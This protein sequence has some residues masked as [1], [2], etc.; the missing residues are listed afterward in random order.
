VIER[1]PQNTSSFAWSF[2]MTE[3]WFY[4]M[5]GEEFGPVPLAGLKELAE[6]GTISE[7]DEVR[8]AGSADWVVAG[9]V[10]QLGLRSNG[11][12]SVAVA[13][14]GSDAEMKTVSDADINTFSVDAGVDEWFC[15]LG[16]QELGPL[17]IDEL[18]KYAEY[19]QLTADDEV[20]L[21]RNGKWRR[22]GSIGRLVSVLP[23]KSIEKT[24]VPTPVRNQTPA[25]EQSVVSTAD[26]SAVRAKAAPTTAAAAAVPAPVAVPDARV[27]YEVAYEQAKAQIAQSMLAQAEATFKAA[28]EQAKSQVAWAL[29]ANVDRHWWG[30]ASSVEFGP[31]EFN[32]VLGLAKSGQ[33]KPTDLVRNGQFAQFGPASNVPGLFNAVAMIAKAAEALALAKSQAQAAVALAAPSAIVPDAITKPA[34]VPVAVAEPAPTARPNSDPVRSSA[35]PVR[36]TSDPMVSTVPTVSPAARREGVGSSPEIPTRGDSSR[37]NAPGDE[38]RPSSPVPS[39]ENR[40]AGYSSGMGGGYSS[41]MSTMSSYGSQQRPA[42]YPTKP[43]A[44]A[45]R[46]SESTFFSGMKESLK[47]PKAIGSMAVIAFVLLIVGW[48]YLPKSRGAD[49]KRYQAL[50]GLLDE[51]RTARTNPTLMTALMPKAKALGKEIT[52]AV[53]SQASSADRPKQMLLWISRD[54]VPRLLEGGMNPMTAEKAEA[55]YAMRLKEAAYELGLEK[56]PPVD[57]AEMARRASEPD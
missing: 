13:M 3:Q 36:R 39:Q 35:D 40:S 37:P 1:E 46:A 2:V 25:R 42:A 43:V 21:G 30:W 14:R 27:A 45:S 52:D 33:L 34:P 49:I 31:V 32:Q 26:K 4:R 9:D 28:E 38:P 57:L 15:M 47:E 7:Y 12:G 17:G 53:K 16:G 10:E 5:F 54:E 19:E 44:R 41:S 56:R 18:I 50:K 20:K 22:V 48:G 6:S 8:S 11:H 51:F 55:S 23:F 29:A 24:I